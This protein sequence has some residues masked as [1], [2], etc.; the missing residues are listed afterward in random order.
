VIF[1]DVK[2]EHLGGGVVVFRNA[3][4]LDWD[5]VNRI[6][7]EIVDREMDDMYRPA[8]NPDNGL[9]EY[10]NRSGYFFSKNGIDKMPKR[11]SRVHQDTRP[12]VVELFTFIEECKDKYLFKYMHMFPIVFKNIWWK[13]KG[14]LVNY[15][16]ECGGYIGEHSDTSVDYVYG[17]PHPSHQLA[18]RNTLSC[19]VYFGNCVDGR[20]PS[21][22][23]DFTGGHHKFTYLNI[24]Y[25]PQRGDILMF[26]SNY[27]AA[28]EVTPVHSGNRFTYLGWYAHGTP[29]PA[30]N[31]E[32]EDPLANPEKAA[33]SSNVYIPYLREKFLAY[34]DS[35]GED[36]SSGT[37]RLAMGEHA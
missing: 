16:S 33:I 29:N 34:L 25:V 17:L 13:V 19:L 8:I 32:V 22:P 2:A 18:S 26:P 35:I 6:S 30:V 3:I 37:Y 14:H 5:Y 36:K 21:E 1:N 20:K 9:E 15:S 24:D 7:K 23:G 4:D 28:H 11:G 31:E 12:Q 10:I 27:I